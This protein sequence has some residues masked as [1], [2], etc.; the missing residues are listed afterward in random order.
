TA[1]P[2]TNQPTPL[3]ERST[4]VALRVR[5]RSSPPIISAA[6]RAKIA[7]ESQI[8]NQPSLETLAA[9]SLALENMLIG[10]LHAPS[11]S[12][13]TI[14]AVCVRR[15]ISVLR[16]A[17]AH[18]RSLPA[19]QIGH[20]VARRLVAHAQVRHRGVR[21][22][23]LRIANPPHHVVRRVRQ[24]AG[25]DRPPRHVA[26]RR[27]DFAVRAADAAAREHAPAAV[28][29]TARTARAARFRAWLGDSIQARK[30]AAIATTYNKPPGTHMISPASCWSSI[31]VSPHAAAPADCAG[32]HTRCVS[33]SSAPR[34]P[35]CVAVANSVRM[36][37]AYAVL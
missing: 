15:F 20:D 22:D 28:T 37:T 33:V 4:S 12:T 27:T 19:V 34:M 23:R 7:A 8:M 13:A 3:S 2:H 24:L 9:A 30:S 10:V 32:I 31:G 36:P 16:R 6:T 11:E 35:V 17:Y 25:D 29:P 21:L 26:Q 18:E 1:P 14:P 5:W